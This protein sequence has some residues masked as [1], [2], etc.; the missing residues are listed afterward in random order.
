[1]QV[2]VRLVWKS[3]NGLSINRIK[4]WLIFVV[5]KLCNNPMNVSLRAAASNL[6]NN[7]IFFVLS[8]R[9]EFHNFKIFFRTFR[10]FLSF[11]AIWD[12]I[13]NAFR[14]LELHYESIWAEKL[15][16]MSSKWVEKM[17][18]SFFVIRFS[19]LCLF[20]DSEVEKM[21]YR[22]IDT[23]GNSIWIF[24]ADF[25]ALSTTLLEWMFL[26]VLEFHIF[27]FQ[28]WLS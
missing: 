20:D 15:A 1:M 4:M 22:K 12:A 2:N 5:S 13:L 21:K 10:I 6:A 23:H 26:L 3:Q 28:L 24:L 11:W 25:V 17:L 16:D 7:E 8:S 27:R 18:Q 19:F 14:A 9:D